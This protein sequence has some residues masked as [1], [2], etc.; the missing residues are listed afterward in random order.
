VR[1]DSI[2][3]DSTNFMLE[4]RSGIKRYLAGLIPALARAAPDLRF[5]AWMGFLRPAH[6]DGFP[7]WPEP[8][9][10]TLALRLPRRLFERAWMG[11]RLPAESIAPGAR[12]FHSF[13]YHLPPARRAR[14]ILTVF[15]F[16]EVALARLYP[17]E[18][19]RIRR[20][21]ERG[22]R[23]ADCI[24]ASTHATAGDLRAHFDLEGRRIEVVH[25][26][27]EE[28]FRP[29][30]AE[31]VSATRKR[32]GLE[33]PYVLAIGSADPRKNIPF[34]IRAYQRYLERSGD[35]LRLVVA[36]ARH[37]ESDAALAEA[38]RHRPGSIHAA[39]EVS[40]RDWKCLLT[41]AE[42]LIYPSL[43]EGLGLPP[44]EA[45]ACGAPA[46]CSDLPA[47]KEWAGSAARYFD[48]ASEE[49]LAAALAELRGASGLAERLRV[50][51]R[52]QASVFTWDRI[53][54]DYLRIYRRVLE[55]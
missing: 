11:G 26:A 18:S 44:L 27:V 12:V 3:I 42:A 48:P 54:A 13:W 6:R 51:G 47:V 32:L 55:G 2:A 23:E 29:Q 46:I 30:P 5:T 25:G 45:M 41:G 50:A 10:R 19:D 4:R 43:Y 7:T 34:L 21:F 17:G 31:A 35:D 39:G 53:A 37:P 28:S 36:G 8:N 9:I 20:L 16:R 22:L 52:L 24:V 49:S 38:D 15:D 40:D 1:A 14:R 33:G